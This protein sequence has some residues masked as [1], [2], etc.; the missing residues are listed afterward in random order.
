MTG[1]SVC[2][3][4]ADAVT[5]IVCEVFPTCKDKFTSTGSFGLKM[6]PFCSDFWN[7]ADSTETV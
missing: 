4:G 5:S 1:D 3:S 7:P 6:T 2:S